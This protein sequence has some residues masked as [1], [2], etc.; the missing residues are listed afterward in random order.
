MPNKLL[1]II[2]TTALIIISSKVALA[3][4]FGKDSYYE[5]C[6]T[7]QDNCTQKIINNINQ[8]TQQ[9]L[10]QAYSFTSKPIAKALIKSKNKGVDV[11]IIFDKKQYEDNHW[12]IASLE[13][14]KIPIFIDY[15]MEGIA[16]N[17]VMVI[18][19]N[20]VITGSFN[21][22]KAA[23]KYNAENL[24]IIS[25]EDLAKKYKENWQTRYQ[26]AR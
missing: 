2:F 24:L 22:T 15:N 13:K 21:F 25:D 11:E 8:A 19:S 20:K 9:I 4:Q 1:F 23:Q 26:T 7:P 16:H 14:Q 5:V 3:D 17:K 12:L 18:D 10:V 6:F